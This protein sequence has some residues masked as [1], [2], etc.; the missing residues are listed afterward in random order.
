MKRFLGHLFLSLSLV[1]QGL[2]LP[3]V[4]AAS[5]DEAP[6]RVKIGEI[7]EFTGEV[8]IRSKGTWKTL[9][10]VPVAVFN[11]DKVVTKQGR[12]KIELIDTAVI[13]MDQDSNI[14]IRVSRDSSRRVVGKQVNVLVGD[15]LFDVNLKQSRGDFKVRTPDMVAAIRGTTFPIKV[16]ATGR[17]DYDVHGDADVTGGARVSTTAQDWMTDQDV[18]APA[19]QIPASDPEVS[20]LPVQ[21]NAEAAVQAQ[22]QADMLQDKVATMNRH[23]DTT[24]DPSQRIESGVASADASA[25]TA[26]AGAAGA[27]VNYDEVLLL[28]RPVQGDTV[29][30]RGGEPARW[31]GV[32]DGARE[33][34]AGLV[35]LL[36]PNVHAADPPTSDPVALARQAADEAAAAARVARQQ[37]QQAQQ[38][39]QE[40]IRATGVSR[41]ALAEA[42]SA[43]ASSGGA[44]ADISTIAARLGVSADDLAQVR[45]VL[46]AAKAAREQARSA[47]QASKQA[48]QASDAVQKAVATGDDTGARAA[49]SAARAN[50]SAAL[51]N[52]QAAGANVQ[53]ADAVVQ[54][55]PAAAR[56]AA[57][58][59]SK[60]VASANQANTNAKQASTHSQAA[61]DPDADPD[62]KRAA[63]AAAQANAAAAA[64]NGAAA[65]A[66]NAIAEAV[67]N[68]DPAALAKAEAAERAARAAA[69]QASQQAETAD[70]AAE[71]G[72]ADA[73]EDALDEAEDASDAA[74]GELQDM[75]T[76]IDE[77][78]ENELDASPN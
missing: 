59:A 19:S 47:E 52:A 77:L 55:N 17:T 25:A 62:S 21:K 51:A 37:A 57:E 41:Q 16:S 8:S 30:Y 73:A 42:I 13:R 76:E 46:D 36:I 33:L 14:S 15:V 32:M 78:F 53:A 67:N 40:A 9:E 65:K 54:G 12:A 29:Y 45:L 64:A 72:D 60:A 27:Q 34:F 69:S 24:V 74:T 18:T 35:E 20:A 49:L 23:S 43:I 3:A 11:T 31:P 7:T 70:D 44:R 61:N 10:Q 75:D 39:A 4:N 5:A 38:L 6:E 48:Q 28:S 22:R 66:S 58:A 2:W 56:Q 1:M 26:G 50:A 68:N 71:D 63:A